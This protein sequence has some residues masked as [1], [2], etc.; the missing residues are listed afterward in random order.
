MTSYL[1]WTYEQ[2][3]IKRMEKIHQKLFIYHGIG[4]L[5]E[6]LKSTMRVKM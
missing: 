5:F 2:H 6:K 3:D 4:A 1:G